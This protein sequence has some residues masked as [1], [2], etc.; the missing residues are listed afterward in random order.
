MARM[1]FGGVWHEAPIWE[2]DDLKPESVVVGTAR[3]D[4]AD[5]TTVVPPGWVARMD[6]FGNIDIRKE[7]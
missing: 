6:R 1:M 5:T 7:A 3:I 4:Q 2:R